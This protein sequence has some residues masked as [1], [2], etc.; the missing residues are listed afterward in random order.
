VSGAT[1]AE[2]RAAGKRVA[3]DERR[4]HRERVDGLKLQ[5]DQEMRRLWESWQARIREAR[6]T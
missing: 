1:G 6:A 4:R 5:R 2:V 3:R